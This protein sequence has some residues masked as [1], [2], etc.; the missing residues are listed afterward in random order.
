MP[1]SE[2]IAQV[3][4]M[5]GF[6]DEIPNDVAPAKAVEPLA[7][8]ELTEEEKYMLSCFLP[9]LA[10]VIEREPPSHVEETRKL[11]QE[12]LAILLRQDRAQRVR[13]AELEGANENL[14]TTLNDW[15]RF[16]PP[17]F[18]SKCKQ[19]CS[20]NGCTKCKEGTS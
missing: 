17:F 11:A 16:V 19:P 2:I 9:N 3:A 1:K 18:C 7:G 12:E 6:Q 10:C 20:S 8:P 4:A 14:K 5:R 13:I 15:S